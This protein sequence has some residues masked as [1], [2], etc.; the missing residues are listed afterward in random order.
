MKLSLLEG[1]RFD[2]PP[3]EGAVCS[4]FTAVNSSAFQSSACEEQHTQGHGPKLSHVG[5][6]EQNPTPALPPFLINGHM[7]QHYGCK[8]H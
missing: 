6:F 4:G 1:K 2:F 8:C 7:Q 3:L 5:I